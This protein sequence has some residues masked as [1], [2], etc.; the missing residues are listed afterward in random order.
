MKIIENL[1]M[2]KEE[3][4]ESIKKLEKARDRILHTGVITEMDFDLYDR[5]EF[6]RIVL[7]FINGKLAIEEDLHTEVIQSLTYYGY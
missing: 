6:R 4:E 5:E 1:Q 2:Q 7:E 3:T